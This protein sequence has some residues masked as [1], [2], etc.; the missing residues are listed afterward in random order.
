MEG[1]DNGMAAS[2]RY[3]EEK[4]VIE[5]DCAEIYSCTLQFNSQHSTSSSCC[6]VGGKGR[7]MRIAHSLDTN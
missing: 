1:Q 4:G 2:K 7:D 5:A 6:L 3:R